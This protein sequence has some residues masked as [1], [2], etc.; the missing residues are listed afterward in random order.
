LTQIEVNPVQPNVSMGTQVSFVAT[1][2]YS[3]N[4]TQNVTNQATWLSSAPAVAAISTANGSK[5]QAQTLANGTATISASFG[6]VTGSTLLTV[7]PATLTAIQIT[8][9][10]PTVLVG[11]N[12]NLVATGLYSDNTTRDLTALVT[13]ASS[14]ADVA[15]ISNANGSRGLLS[16]ISAG[17]ATLTAVY[18]GIT[19]SDAVLVSSATLTGITVS[20][21]V[22]TLASHTTQP[23]TALG[24][25]SDATTLD[26]TSYVTWLSTMPTIASISNANG[27]RGVASALSTG[28]VTISAVRGALS[29]T[30]QLTVQ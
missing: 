13:W 22:T 1:A 11:F 23:F 12:T 15:G 5:G 2:I 25:L 27:S 4:S 16:P 10:S 7:T 17:K 28:T 8:P 21:A 26:I 19:G 30:A 6:G 14:A 9:F 18:Q 20:P 24:T 29:G 3:D